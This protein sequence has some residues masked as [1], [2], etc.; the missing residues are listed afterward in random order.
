MNRL[1]I[2]NL[3][4]APESFGGA[5]IVAEETSRRLQD[6]H[7]WAVLVVTTMRDHS[8]PAFFLKRYKANGVNVVAI[9][10][11]F[12]FHG[13]DS[14]RNPAVAKSVLEIARAFKPDVC[15]CHAIQII[16]CGFFEDFIDD[17][18]KLAITVH[19]C[20]WICERQFMINSDGLYCNQ[21]RIDPA[22]CNYCTADTPLMHKRKAYLRERLEQANLL[23]YPSE[24]HKRLH[25]VNSLNEKISRVNK[26]GVTM[27]LAGYSKKRTE[28]KRRSSQVVFGFTG[29]P[30]FMKGSDQIIE[31]FNNIERTDYTLKVV[32]AAANV[33]ASWK[34]ANYWKIPGE[35]EFVPPY[36]QETMDDFFA[37]IDILLFPSR[38]KESFGLTVREALVRD[39]WVIASDAGGV[40][41][42]LEDGINADVVPFG[43]GVGDLQRA[44]E[45]S[46]DPGQWS[47]YKNPSSAD[48]RGFDEQSRELSR[49]LSALI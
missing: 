40:T 35:L 11:P 47:S 19:D 13:E 36:S 14:F 24:F 9:N 4:Y 48:I 33:G 17:G 1:L 29:G 28:H 7:D 23:L 27:P 3:Y 12:D 37:S 41:E 5:T 38:W 26:N 8:L 6:H 39:V 22:Q 46:L 42:D 15:H 2:L 18:I 44:I 21:W 20:W 16:G 31:A 25:L 10:L 32:D 34:D 49:Y 30:G 43:S 45:K